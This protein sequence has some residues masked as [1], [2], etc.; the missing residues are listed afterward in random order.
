MLMATV[1]LTTCGYSHTYFLYQSFVFSRLNV[2]WLDMMDYSHSNRI[3]CKFIYAKRISPWCRI[4][5]S[6]NRV[7][8]ASYN[9]FSFVRRKGIIWTNVASLLIWYLGT[10]SSETRI[11]MHYFSFMHL[12]MSEMAAI[13]FREKYA[14]HKNS[15][16]YNLVCSL[17]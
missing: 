7:S 15:I 8:I 6:V 13:L 1:W 10:N 12:N 3:L 14:K 2:T 5:A 9:G 16:H 17:S 4:Y 11:K